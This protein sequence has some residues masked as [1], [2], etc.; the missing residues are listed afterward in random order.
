VFIIGSLLVSARRPDFKTDW[1]V[2]AL[3]LG[4]LGWSLQGLVEFSLYIPSLAWPAFAFIGWLL[5][6]AGLGRDKSIDNPISAA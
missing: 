5:A 2:F 1:V 4:V 6:G 3:W